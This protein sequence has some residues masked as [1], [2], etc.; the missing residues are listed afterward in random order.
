[1]PYSPVYKSHPCSRRTPKQA[2]VLGYSSTI[3][4]IKSHTHVQDAP[5]LL[6]LNFGQKGA[7]KTGV[8]TV[9]ASAR[10]HHTN[11]KGHSSLCSTAMPP[12]GVRSHSLFAQETSA[13][14][15]DTPSVIRPFVMSLAM[16]KSD[17]SSE[18]CATSQPDEQGMCLHHT[19]E[20]WRSRTSRACAS[21][22]QVKHGAPDRVEQALNL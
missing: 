12:G 20:A 16:N 17:G 13:P 3:K 11:W 6:T 2:L 18:N 9:Q 14:T 5:L 21:T 8:G 15:R 7:S 10:F 22:T 1:M 4:K 19:G